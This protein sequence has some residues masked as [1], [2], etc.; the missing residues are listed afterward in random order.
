MASGG[1]L[2]S[3]EMFEHAPAR[4]MGEVRDDEPPFN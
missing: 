2:L 1:K 4:T 3:I